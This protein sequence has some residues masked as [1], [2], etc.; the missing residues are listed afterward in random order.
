MN[1]GRL[2]ASAVEAAYIAEW[3]SRSFQGERASRPMD[4]QMNTTRMSTV[5][6]KSLQT[7]FQF[8]RIN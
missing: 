7:M 3:C 1:F 8:F 6:T 2:A 5:E 4:N